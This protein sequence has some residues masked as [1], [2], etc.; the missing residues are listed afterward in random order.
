MGQSIHNAS[1]GRVPVL[2]VAGLSPITQ[3]GEMLGSRTEYVAQEYAGDVVAAD[4]IQVHSL[5]SGCT[6][7]KRHCQTVL[8]IYRGDPCCSQCRANREQSTSD[9]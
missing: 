9:L 4:R 1:V 2:M 7:P 3:E 8:Q 6:R 5:D